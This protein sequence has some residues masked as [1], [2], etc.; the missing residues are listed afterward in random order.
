MVTNESP[1]IRDFVNNYR[2]LRHTFQALDSLR[3]LKVSLSWGTQK[4]STTYRCKSSELPQTWA[5]SYTK[6]SSKKSCGTWRSRW[7]RWRQR[8]TPKSVCWKME[9]N[10]VSKTPWTAPSPMQT[11]TEHERPRAL[12]DPW[13]RIGILLRS[14]EFL[15]T[16]KS[17][18][19]QRYVV[20]SQFAWVPVSTSLFRF[21]FLSRLAILENSGS[22]FFWSMAGSPLLA[23]PCVSLFP[24][25]NW[26]N[27]TDDDFNVS[28]AS[29]LSPFSWPWGKGIS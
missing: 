25:A 20:N 14:R 17:A 1:E 15:G 21:S 10:S 22:S 6:N 23:F 24:V 5:S 3:N 18:E 8:L 4:P 26:W 19:F 16:K 29:L 28:L 27:L 11:V 9:R 13:H 7:R 2:E 12:Q